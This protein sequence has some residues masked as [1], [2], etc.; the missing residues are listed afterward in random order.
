MG[1]DPRCQAGAT[2]RLAWSRA[3][4]SPSVSSPGVLFLDLEA[5]T[6]GELGSVVTFC[7]ALSTRHASGN[8]KPVTTLSPTSQAWD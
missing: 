1:A 5:I 7:A 4:V 2:P 3:C 6:L 8:S